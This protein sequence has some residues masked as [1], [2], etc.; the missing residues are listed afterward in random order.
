MVDL[1]TLI[2]E[3]AGALLYEPSNINGRGEIVAGGLPAGC[4]DPFSCGHAYLLIPCGEGGE[5]CENNADGAAA[6]Q[7][8]STL[9]TPRNATTTPANSALGGQP[10]GMLD[11]LRSR[12]GQRY[13]IP[14]RINGPTN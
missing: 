12:W 14:G 2:P 13:R 11:R 10:A 1:N 6:T 5:D 9:A 8:S 4:G 3:N 7:S